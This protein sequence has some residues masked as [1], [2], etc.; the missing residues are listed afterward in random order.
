MELV[1]PYSSR[2]RSLQIHIQIDYFDSDSDYSDDSDS[3]ELR[4]LRPVDG[5]LDQLKNSRIGDSGDLAEIPHVFSTAPNLC[6]V[7]LGDCSSLLE[8]VIPWQQITR[9][10]GTY[11]PMRQL[12]ILTAA[13]ISWTVA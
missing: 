7:F 2:W 13:P 11:T 4:W 10:R 12:E 6:E 5:R 1:L 9:Y 8:I 3:I